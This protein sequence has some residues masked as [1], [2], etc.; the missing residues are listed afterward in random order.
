[1]IDAM[2][3]YDNRQFHM[4][5]WPGVPLTLPPLVPRRG[6]YQLDPNGLALIGTDG[7]SDVEHADRR[8]IYLKLY[9]LDLE[10]PAAIVAFANDHGTPRSGLVQSA[11]AGHSWFNGLFD[12]D[13]DRQL[14]ET[15]KLHNAPLRMDV[16]HPDWE[17]IDLVTLDSFRFAARLLCDLTDAWRIVRIDPTFHL[18]G[19]WRLPYNTDG[20]TD[21]RSF[22][23]QLLT[24]GLTPLLAR[25]R[26]FIMGTPMPEGEEDKEHEAIEAAPDPGVRLEASPS[27]RF[28]HLA[29]FCALELFNHIV[30]S[31][32]YRICRNANC[33][34]LFV[35]QYGLQKH[36]MSKR[37][38]V[39]YCSVLCAQAKAAR[40][41]R[42]RK[43]AA[44]GS[45]T[46]T[47]SRLRPKQVRS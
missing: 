12:A 29:E 3:S 35:L 33:G 13:E 37:Q 20:E 22:A 36:G 46:A 24:H 9:S 16:T 15:V 8:E 41:Y 18:T 27:I 6:R 43:K 30:A 4:T 5:L 26:P 44:S 23:T 7:W 10:D 14:L 28:A 2:E 1:M 45:T 47:R 21:D 39:M 17:L 25:F 11:V 31:E 42:A 34:R 19:H 40:D 32:V 38:G